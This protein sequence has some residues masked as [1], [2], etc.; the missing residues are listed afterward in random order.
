MMTNSTE[1][2]LLTSNH[3]EVPQ[4]AF[5][6]YK[7]YQEECAKVIQNAINVGYRHFDSAS[8]Y[9]NEA[10][11]GKGLEEALLNGAVSRSELCICSKV[12]KDAVKEGR[13][14]VRLSIE[15]SISDLCC[16]YL[17]I[18][19]IHW[20]V[21]NFHVEAYK[22]LELMVAEGKILSIGLSNYLPKD[23]EDL[24]SANISI[25]PIVNQMEISPFMY[26]PQIIGY[27]AKKNIVVESHKSLHRG[28]CLENKIIQEM[29]LALSKSPA[30]IMVR[31]GIQKGFIV[32]CKTSSLSRMKENRNVFDFTLSEKDIERLDALTDGENILA[33]H[34]Q[35]LRSK[36]VN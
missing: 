14:A 13:A 27:F 2:S 11:V 29:S 7:V 30:Q 12:W 3:K 24:L 1:K 19:M 21:S 25:Q 15:K 35:E 4:L 28:N 17:D 20:P 34:Q 33:R 9:G 16:E 23:Y 10:E 8:F 6:C 32:V 31:W 36:L 18:A 26:R 22:E 5:G